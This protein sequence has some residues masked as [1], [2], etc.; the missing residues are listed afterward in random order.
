M[1]HDQP[2]VSGQVR[3]HVV[4]ADGVAELIDDEIVGLSKMLPHEI[5]RVVHER[6]VVWSLEFPGG[7]PRTRS[8]R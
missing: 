6:A 2:R 1:E 8:I 3:P 5:V 4:V 7:R